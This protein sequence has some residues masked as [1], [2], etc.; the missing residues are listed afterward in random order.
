MCVFAADSGHLEVL[1][2]LRELGCQWNADSVRAR[3]AAGGHQ[4]VLSWLDGHGQ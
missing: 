1:K 4:E 3:A 2:W